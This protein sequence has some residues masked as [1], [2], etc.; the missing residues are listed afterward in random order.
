MKTVNQSYRKSY[1]E[2]VLCI[3]DNL[4][5]LIWRLRVIEAAKEELIFVTFDTEDDL[6][7]RALMAALLH[8]AD[9]GVRVR[10][11]IDGISA[12][13]HQKKNDCFIS[14]LRWM[15]EKG[16]FRFKDLRCKEVILN[17]LSYK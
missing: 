6:S 13:L 8:A 3:D 9:R 5:A 15:F 7:G 16:C 17:V 2:R 12:R 1:Q 11:L 4:D 14:M 10:I